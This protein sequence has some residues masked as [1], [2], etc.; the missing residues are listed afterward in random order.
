MA[1]KQFSKVSYHVSNTDTEED[2]IGV[3]L[4]GAYNVGKSEGNLNQSSA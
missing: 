2:E 1:S 4:D 3:L